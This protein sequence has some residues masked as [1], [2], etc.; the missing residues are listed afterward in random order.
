MGKSRRTFQE[1]GLEQA[2]EQSL[3]H[4]EAATAQALGGPLGAESAHALNGVMGNAA[5]QQLV[6]AAQVDASPESFTEQINDSIYELI[7]ACL[8]G[9]M[10]GWGTNERALFQII[11]DCS[12]AQRERVLS[13]RALM[14]RFRS[15]LT[16]DEMFLMLRGLQAP[17]HMWVDLALSTDISTRDIEYFIAHSPAVEQLELARDAGL[18]ARLAAALTVQEADRIFALLPQEGGGSGAVR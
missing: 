9:A 7:K 13:D 3:Q 10:D 5:V 15:E 8:D 2:P 17:L 1:Q 12:K 14:A 6:G 18:M 16:T 11:A 4:D